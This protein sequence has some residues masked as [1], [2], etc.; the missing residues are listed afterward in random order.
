PWASLVHAQAPRSGTEGAPSDDVSGRFGL[1]T[2]LRGRSL[3]LGEIPGT[4]DR[5]LSGLEQ[6]RVVQRDRPVDQAPTTH[7]GK[8]LP[9]TES[10]PVTGEPPGIQPGGS[11]AFMQAWLD[12]L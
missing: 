7:E 1:L 2:E 10:L 5:A 3:T 11:P 8:E 6:L 4:M 9:S 12:D